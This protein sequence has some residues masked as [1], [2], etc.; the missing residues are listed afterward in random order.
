MVF[1]F[2]D[3]NNRPLIGN[4]SNCGLLLSVLYLISL[5][6]VF[7]NFGLFLLIIV[8]Q[9]IIIFLDATKIRVENN[10]HGPNPLLFALL[11]IILW[12]IVVPV[13]IYERKKYG[14]EI[15]QKV[16]TERSIIK[17]KTVNKLPQSSL[18]DPDKKFIKICS[19][20]SSIHKLF[21]LVVEKFNNN[22]RYE[23]RDYAQQLIDT[24]D[25]YYNSVS[26][27]T[28]LKYLEEKELF[29]DAM[30]HFID[31]GTAIKSA[32]DSVEN[33]ELESAKLF[34][35]N[36]GEAG[37]VAYKIL[38]KMIASIK[39]KRS[40]TTQ[41][42]E[43]SPK[44]VSIKPVIS[45]YDLPY[46][47]FVDENASSYIESEYS[48]KPLKILTDVKTQSNPTKKE[49]KKGSSLNE[50]TIW[51]GDF[52]EI[53]IHNYL[54]PNPLIYWTSKKGDN[55]EASC[56]NVNLPIG[57]PISEQKGSLGYWPQYSE[58]SPDQRSNYL[59]WLSSGR[60]EV[61]SD[62]GYAFLFFYGLE[63]RGLIER[64]DIP[65]IIQEVNTLLEKYT[66]SGS[67][68]QYLSSFLAYISAKE[69]SNISEY[70]YSTFFPH[71]LNLSYD[72]VLVALAWHTNNSKV[73]P[74]EIA[75]SL[76]N[77]I[78]DTPKSIVTKKLSSQF[79]RLFE[80]KFKSIYPNGLII[81][82]STRNYKLEYRPASPSL[83]PYY[84]NYNKERLIEAIEISNPLGKKSQFK[85]VFTIWSEI[86]EELKPASKR[87][88]KG[89]EELTAQAY[90]A[91][92]DSLKQEL[93]H[94]EKDRWD[95]VIA[96]YN[97]EGESIILPVSSL[98]NLNHIEERNRLTPTQSKFLFLTAR[99]VGYVLIPDPSIKGNPYLWNDSIAIYPLPDKKTF[100]SDT[101]PSVAFILELGMSI[102]LADGRFSP[103]EQEHLDRF[104]FGSSKLTP[105][106][107]ECLKQ[108]QKILIK[109]P[110]SL[111]K[112]GKR[113][114]EHL[115][116]N[117][118]LVIA[119]YLRDMAIADGNIDSTE[120][121]T[122]NKIYK[123]MGLGKEDIQS[124]F[125]PE[126]P[127]I[128]SE[129][130][131]Q[132]SHPSSTR[133]G[134]IIGS[135]TSQKTVI[136]LDHDLVRKK[137]NETKVIQDILESVINQEE[138]ELLNNPEATDD[139]PIIENFQNSDS[140][141]IKTISSEDI[142]TGLHS[143]YIP[144]LKDVVIL[145]SIS[146]LELHNICRNYRFMM[147]ATI[148]DINSWSDDSFGDCLFDNTDENKVSFNSDVKMKILEKIL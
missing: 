44:D 121:N 88:G 72:Q 100:T 58:I 117:N 110:P 116:E 20:S 115:T 98:A 64:K 127:A 7:I 49:V 13:Y 146:K 52:K 139:Y 108:Y 103:E 130:P 35:N 47:T 95:Q 105:L 42:N 55:I 132:I 67:F 92:P 135:L 109:T 94:P 145:N 89:V 113:L 25:K 82:S 1:L 125:P 91:L 60:N 70:N 129:L 10:D 51:A 53:Q 8:S 138:E 122:L 19:Q 71:P 6:F 114:K 99:D 68:N 16:Q 15:S 11:T 134:E 69:L 5:I 43:S 142:F 33:K 22:E 136:T 140:L 147:D 41:K 31:S 131:I 57:K 119:K 21:K 24:S 23:A 97:L 123:A 104:I 118:R 4:G 106:D 65:T 17:P 133:H 2:E 107:I 126:L 59:E 12:I 37:T 74:W 14:T 34:V 73:I 112:L 40:I 62:I 77:T 111:E 56:I 143:R 61:L 83:L 26:H 36:A 75:Y 30:N 90:E 81:E 96:Q 101:Y 120:Y 3:L 76:A 80:T 28:V 85:K 141:K 46:P 54:I 84:Q 78:P 38:V 124:L 27:I 29:L 102:A 79:K 128:P 39:Q 50:N 45:K 86:I 66:F 144:F 137:L 48:Y 9:S 148:E 93:D 63:Y 32:L 18:E 87:V